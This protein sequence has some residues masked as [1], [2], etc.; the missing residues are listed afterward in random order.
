M[1]VQDL[2][3]RSATGAPQRVNGF[4]SAS[5]AP[6]MGITPKLEV[7]A[8]RVVAIACAVLGSALAFPLGVPVK[9]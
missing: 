7:L 9:P 4:M 6:G 8:P 5:T 1:G 2:T 3:S